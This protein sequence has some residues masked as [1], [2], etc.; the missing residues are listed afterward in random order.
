MRPSVALTSQAEQFSGL[1]GGYAGCM[2]PNADTDTD[3][4]TG[5]E[6]GAG[7]DADAVVAELS[8]LVFEVST[9]DPRFFAGAAILVAV[10]ALIATYVPARPRRT[11][12]SARR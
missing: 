5:A 8:S 7:T 4:D 11:A 6:T 9:T 12:A 2:S 1:S 10:V 3:S